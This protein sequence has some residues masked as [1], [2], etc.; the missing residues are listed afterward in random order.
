MKYYLFNPTGNMTVLA[1]SY[2]PSDTIMEM[3]PSCEQVGYIFDKD[4]CDI[5]IRMAGG[6]FCGN[7]SMCAALLTGKQNASVFVEGTGIVNVTV[8]GGKGFV[9]MPKPI[10]FT[11]RNGYTIV[12][13]KGIDHCIA[14]DRLDPGLIS[15]WC[16]GE[17]MGFMYLNGS[18]MKPL[19]YVKNIN[20]IFWENSCASGTAAVGEYLKRRVELRQPG[21]ILAYEDGILEGSV[22][23][24]KEINLEDV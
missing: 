19:V 3:E 5:A 15:S 24:E 7:A 4:G 22:K 21:G 13:F 1:D 8:S 18:E 23:V 16:E 17:A 11:S 14:D 10:D 6:E 2:I 20:T 12:R 9:T